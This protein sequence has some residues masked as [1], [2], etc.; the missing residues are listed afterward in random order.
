MIDPFARSL[1]PACTSGLATS[2]I[3]WSSSAD[4]IWLATARFH[5]SSYSRPCSALRKPR[6][7]SSVRDTSVGRTA[8]WASCAF[9]AFAWYS[10]GASGRYCSPNPVATYSRVASIASRAIETPSVLM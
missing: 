10:R 1:G 8:S 5:T 9:F 7:C 6:S 2:T 4:C 3:T